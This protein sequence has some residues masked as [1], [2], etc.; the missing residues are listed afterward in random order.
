MCLFRNSLLTIVRRVQGHLLCDFVLLANA[1]YS[2]AIGFGRMSVDLL[3]NSIAIGRLYNIT[4]YARIT[5]STFTMHFSVCIVIAMIGETI[6][7]C[8]LATISCATLA[9]MAGSLVVEGTFDT[10]PNG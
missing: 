10:R 6:A 2:H 1:V 4:Q 8:G 3:T 7:F 9:S 5:L